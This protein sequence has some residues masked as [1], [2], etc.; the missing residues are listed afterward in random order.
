[1]PRS[2]EIKLTTADDT[3]IYWASDKTIK[4]RIVELERELCVVLRRKI[5]TPGLAGALRRKINRFKEIQSARSKGLG[6]VVHR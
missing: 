4:N 2:R 1:M 5:P 3:G 6:A